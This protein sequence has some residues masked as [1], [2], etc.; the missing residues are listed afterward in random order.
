M[1]KT[2]AGRVF[3]APVDVVERQ[4]RVLVVASGKG[5][6][7]TSLLASL[8]A[9]GAS[10]RVLLVDATEGNGALHLLFGVRPS[11][12]LWNLYERG[13]LVEDALIEVGGI[14]LVAGGTSGDATVPTT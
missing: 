7:G 9:L 10:G 6:V 11:C 13:G 8:I 4:S 12:G 14:T 5:G 2:A 1:R 3:D